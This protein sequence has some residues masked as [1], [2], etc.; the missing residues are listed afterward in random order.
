MHWS[1]CNLALSHQHIS[2]SYFTSTLASCDLFNPWSSGLLNKNWSSMIIDVYECL[3]VIEASLK[4][5]VKWITWN[6]NDFG[7]DLSVSGRQ[8]QFELIHAYEMTHIASSSMEELSYCFQ[9]LLTNFE[10]TRAEKL[11][12]ISFEIPRPVAAVRSLRFVSFN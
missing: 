4:N 11:I 2:Q 9:G 7:S 10:V 12:W 5:M 8:L 3:S 1:Y 6:I